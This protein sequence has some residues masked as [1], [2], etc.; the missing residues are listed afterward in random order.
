MS[1]NSLPMRPT[2]TPFDT[3]RHEDERGA[4]WT[5][6]ELMPLLEYSTWQKFSEVLQR[7]MEDC[8]KAGRPVDEHFNL[9]VKNPSS[10][11]GRP[12]K[13]YRLTRYACRLV[14]MASRVGGDVAALA[15]TYF[16]DMVDAA[17]E[18]DIAEWQQCAIRS[19]IAKGYSLEWAQTRVKDI[20]ARNALTHEWYVRDIREDEYAILTDQLHM[21]TFGLS[22][23]EHKALKDFPIVKRGKRLTYRG[24]LP[25]A[26]TMTELAL[27]TLASIAARELHIARDSRSHDAISRDV[28]DAARIA[29]NARR[30]LEAQAGRPI[31]SRRNMVQKSGWRPVGTAAESG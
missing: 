24:D 1:D 25:P 28:D 27:N 12:Q 7:A 29:A 8:E 17:E 22:V 23:A 10:K 31:V 20:L 5:A 4:Y 30:E 6:R 3:I 19:Y 9:L 15:R 16:S 18:A 21:G 11:G 13:D 14:V 2:N 26:M